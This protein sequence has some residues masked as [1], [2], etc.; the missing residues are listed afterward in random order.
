MALEHETEAEL[1]EGHFTIDSWKS[2]LS[3]KMPWRHIIPINVHCIEPE[4]F[5]RVNAVVSDV[6]EDQQQ[7]SPIAKK[8]PESKSDRTSE[9]HK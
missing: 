4:S 9:K 5:S 2:R 3:R 8:K 1:L 6:L 7:N